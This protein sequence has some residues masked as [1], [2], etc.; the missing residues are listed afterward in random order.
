MDPLIKSRRQ[1]DALW[2]KFYTAA[3]RRQRRCVERANQTLQYRL[4]KELRLRG[5]SRTEEANIF[6]RE[7]IEFWVYRRRQQ[8]DQLQT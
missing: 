1:K 6:A 2:D 8:D 7:F 5:I 3:P 4:A